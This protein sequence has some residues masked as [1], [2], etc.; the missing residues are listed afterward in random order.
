MFSWGTGLLPA[1]AAGAFG[2]LFP[3]PPLVSVCLAVCPCQESSLVACLPYSLRQ[4]LSV[5]P[6]SCLQ[7]LGMGLLPAVIPTRHFCGFLE[8]PAPV[9]MLAE[10]A[11]KLPS[12]LSGL[13]TVAF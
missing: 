5:R 11:F 4:S 10:Q 13:P 3:L 2:F 9:L 7:L 12:H 8:T 1:P 6:R